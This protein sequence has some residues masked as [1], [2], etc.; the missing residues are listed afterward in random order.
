M[1]IRALFTPD[2]ADGGVTPTPTP[3]AP[4]AP[5]APPPPP[6]A[7]VVAAAAIT[8]ETLLLQQQIEAE[9]AARK[10]VEQDHASVTDEFQRYKDATE[11]RATVSVR[12]GKV[13]HSTARRFG[14]LRRAK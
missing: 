13:D 12:P 10:R 8:E 5:P 4:E 9:R 2:A 3:T 1:L 6:A 7:T 11:A 14:F